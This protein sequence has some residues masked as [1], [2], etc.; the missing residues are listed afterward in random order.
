[1]CVTCLREAVSNSQGTNASKTKQRDNRYIRIYGI[2]VNEYED[3]LKV[4]NGMCYICKKIPK[5]SGK[6]L[7]IDHLHS[8]GERQ[9][10]PREKR[11]RVRGLLCWGCNAAL[12]GF[13]D[14]I[15]LL[16][17]AANYLEIWPAQQILKK[18]K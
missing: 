17:E 3:I 15:T 9:R 13:N 18:E 10:N 4:Q 12:G 14:N 5:E 8:K 11:G 1:M 16:R 6:R 2:T 7:A